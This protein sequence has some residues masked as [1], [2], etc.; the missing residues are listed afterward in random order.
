MTPTWRSEDVPSIDAPGLAHRFRAV[1]RG[2]CLVIIL[3]TGAV[4]SLVLRGIEALLHGQSRPWTGWVTVF[5]CRLSLVVLGLKVTTHGAPLRGKGVFVANHSSWLDILVLNA[6]AP[7]V[8]VSKAE[9]ARWPG[10]GGLA[11]LTGTVFVQRAAREAG[12]QKK[13]LEQRI[14]AGNRLLFFPEGTSTDGQRVLTFKPTLFAALYGNEAL[15]VQ[16]VTVAY[17]APEGFDRRFFSWWGDMSFGP[18][19]AQVLSAP[20]GGSVAVTWHAPL[21]VTEF[22]DR[23]TLARAAEAAVRSAHPQGSAV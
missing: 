21:N 11:R 18:H 3:L 7:L 5:V 8:F 14:A 16:P 1:L 2:F 13:L 20:K 15:A 23:K 6:G 22:S 17:R 9:V 4:L 10:I 12:Q 19:M